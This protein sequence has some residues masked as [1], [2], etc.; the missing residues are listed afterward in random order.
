MEVAFIFFFVLGDP[1][2]WNDKS[3]E[4]KESIQKKLSYKIRDESDGRDQL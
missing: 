2:G 3:E 1:L 4:C